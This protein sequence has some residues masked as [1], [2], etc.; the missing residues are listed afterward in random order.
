MIKSC[1]GIVAA[2]AFLCCCSQAEARDELGTKLMGDRPGTQGPEWV[3]YEDM[4]EDG[5]IVSF[6]QAGDGD[7]AFEICQSEDGAV[8]SVAEGQGG[9][10]CDTK[11]G[12]KDNF[13][14]L[15]VPDQ[16]DQG[17]VDEDEGETGGIAG[18]LQKKVRDHHS[19]ESVGTGM[20][21]DFDW[22]EEEKM[23]MMKAL[24]E[25][26][27]FQR[28]LQ[29]APPKQ[30]V[31]KGF[32]SFGHDA[33]SDVQLAPCMSENYGVGCVDSAEDWANAWD[34]LWSY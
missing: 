4:P 13:Y 21:P 26:D 14:V 15:R 29:E 30:A 7:G 3:L 8:G 25:T 12:A 27:A 33:R 5:E 20:M 6:N 24:A 11:D 22:S 19:E 31:K 9:T 16:D 28:F 18:K 17:G 23:E 2:V 32:I 1:S 10:L 34:A